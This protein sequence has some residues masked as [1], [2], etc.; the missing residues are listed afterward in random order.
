MTHFYGQDR[1]V[2][3]QGLT[4]KKKKKKSN[5]MTHFYGQDRQLPEANA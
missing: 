4:K 3:K 2:Y 5:F 1:H